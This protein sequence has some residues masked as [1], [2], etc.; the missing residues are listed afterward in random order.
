M[1]SVDAIAEADPE[2]ERSRFFGFDGESAR[3]AT[4]AQVF[5]RDFDSFA[6]ALE[7]VTQNTGRVLPS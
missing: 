7:E 1:S 5:S 2:A 3:N 4:R 6:L